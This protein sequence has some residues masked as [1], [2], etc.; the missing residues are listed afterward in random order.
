VG[1]FLNFVAFSEYVDFTKLFT[2]MC[3]ND[4][5]LEVC[6]SNL[7]YPIAPF[8]NGNI[9]ITNPMIKMVVTKL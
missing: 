6:Q 1:D 9:P 2:W 4:E 8:Q 5:G 7:D 3:S